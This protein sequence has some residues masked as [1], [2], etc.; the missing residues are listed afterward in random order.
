MLAVGLVACAAIFAASLEYRGD[1]GL[2]SRDSGQYWT[3]AVNVVEGRGFSFDGENPTRMRQPIYPLTL[4]GMISL[5]GET[6]RP[7]QVLQLLF[8][9]AI[10]VVTA[11]IARELF[12]ERVAG[13][14]ALGAGLYYPLPVLATEIRPEAL[15]VLLLGLAALTGCTAL[16]RRS[17]GRAAAC[18]LFLGLAMLTRANGASFV[19][20]VP[21]AAW[22]VLP[23]R[24]RSW[25]EP[26]AMAA[27]AVLVVLPWGVRNHVALGEFSVMSDAGP[28]SIYVGT[29]PLAIAAWSDYFRTI[30]ATEEYQELLGD[31]PYLGEEPRERFEAAVQRRLRED[32]WGVAWRG[33]VKIALTWTY[34]PGSRPML[35][36][37]E[38]LFRVLQIPQV[39]LLGLIVHG[40]WR[41][42]RRARLFA[43]AFFVATSASMFLG[44]PTARYTLPF[45][46]LGLA[47]AANGL[48]SLRLR[49]RPIPG[50]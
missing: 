21:L 6:V 16:R 14:S 49:R 29:H 2:Y 42:G 24:E 19:G 35:G 5:F 34:A 17:I 11:A 1:A 10:V 45:M 26:A 9:L 8:T 23:G 36:R 27:V 50:G 30:E 15:F 28:A 44:A 18:G 41:G 43:V 3:L 39:L 13:L 25:R 22:L 32:P 37:N 12:G 40:T 48:L 7:I 33:V 47:L 20:L 38:A 46:P 4:A 31:G